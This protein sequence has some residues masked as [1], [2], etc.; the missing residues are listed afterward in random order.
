MNNLNLNIIPKYRE[1]LV[2][3]VPIYL[4]HRKSTTSN[5]NVQGSSSSLRQQ[6]MSDV[7]DNRELNRRN[8]AT[9]T[10]FIVKIIVNGKQV[11]CNG[12]LLLINFVN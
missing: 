4:N 10:K 3:T 2:Y 9:K 5:E 12:L 6:G 1:C 8:A 11:S 7:T